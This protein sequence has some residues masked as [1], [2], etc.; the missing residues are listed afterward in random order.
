MRK[1]IAAVMLSAAA[2]APAHAWGDREQGILAGIAGLWTIQQLNKAGQV[3]GV[4]QHIQVTPPPMVPYH[5]GTMG[6]GDFIHRPMYR[7][8]DVYIPECHCYRTIMVQV[9]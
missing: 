6:Q 2:V 3:Q 4:P 5:P 7:A 1:L 8:V 9:N